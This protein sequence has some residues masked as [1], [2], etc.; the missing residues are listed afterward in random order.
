MRSNT[1]WRASELL[2]LKV[3]KVGYPEEGDILGRKQSKTSKYR[4]AKFNRAVVR[5][6]KFWL[7]VYQPQISELPLS[8]SRHGKAAISAP[9]FRGMEKK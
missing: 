4:K 1:V 6:I 5:I 7:V 9:T 2:A 8:P 3:K